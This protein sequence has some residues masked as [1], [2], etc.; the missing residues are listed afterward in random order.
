MSK[1]MVIDISKYNHGRRLLSGRDN[2]H[3]LWNALKVTEFNPQSK[4][5]IKNDGQTVITNSYFLGMLSQLFGHYHQKSELLE[6]ID[7]HELNKTNQQELLRGINR[8]F[9]EAVN[10][11]A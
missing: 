11:M 4:I 6:H 2:G 3:A 5:V 7:Y 8:G 9:S 10:A 1:E